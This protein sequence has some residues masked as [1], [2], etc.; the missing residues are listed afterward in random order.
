MSSGSGP[1]E[2][3]TIWFSVAEPCS[4]GGAT[5][6]GLYTR[7]RL[8]PIP[9][10]LS[11]AGPPGIEG[12]PPL[13]VEANRDLR[14]TC[15][16]NTKQVSTSR[17]G[18]VALIAANTRVLQRSAH[19]SFVLG[20]V[21]RTSPPAPDTLIGPYGAC[22]WTLP[23]NAGFVSLTGFEGDDRLGVTAFVEGGSEQTIRAA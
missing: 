19:C 5:S 13:P 8:L 2:S 6:K 10:V 22:R 1:G 18:R 3:F 14:H 21:R 7:C 11:F 15:P 17:T 4:G 23:E 20:G 9:P 16:L 12:L